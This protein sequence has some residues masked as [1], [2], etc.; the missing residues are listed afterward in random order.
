M[1]LEKAIVVYATS[2]AR[3]KWEGKERPKKVKKV[4]CPACEI[5]NMKNCNSD[6]E[7]QE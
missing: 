3:K 1:K 5:K 2:E 4:S 7:K 6:E